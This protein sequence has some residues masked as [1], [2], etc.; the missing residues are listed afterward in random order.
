MIE[1]DNPMLQWTGKRPLCQNKADFNRPT[2]KKENPNTGRGGGAYLFL[3]PGVAMYEGR[4]YSKVAMALAMI[5]S[6][7]RVSISC[8]DMNPSRSVTAECCCCCTMD[9][10]VS[11]SRDEVR[12]WLQYYSWIRQTMTGLL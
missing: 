5:N 9:R 1:N 12:G 10:T 4:E 8:P 11:C 7:R 2:S 6:V 3:A